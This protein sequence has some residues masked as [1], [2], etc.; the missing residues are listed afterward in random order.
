MT[1]IFVYT[2]WKCEMPLEIKHFFSSEQKE[3][4]EWGWLSIGKEQDK[5][6]GG[7]GHL[8]TFLNNFVFLNHVT[9][10]TLKNF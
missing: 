10:H 3:I 9:F 8:S 2:K 7:D 4:G 1:V 6:D 5:Q